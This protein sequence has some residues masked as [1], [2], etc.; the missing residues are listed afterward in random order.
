M[1]GDGE[2]ADGGKGENGDEGEKNGTNV[3]VDDN[4][5]FDSA[6]LRLSIWFSILYV[7]GGDDSMFRVLSLLEDGTTH[8][9][10]HWR[11][12]IVDYVANHLM[13]DTRYH[14]ED[15]KVLT[16]TVGG[17]MSVVSRVLDH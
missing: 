8:Y 6:D 12:K 1:E 9:H 11:E 2:V 14:G 15:S 3:S 13:K 17:N 4:W 10:G 7:Q 5:F 16:T